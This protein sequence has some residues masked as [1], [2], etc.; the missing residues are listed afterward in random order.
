MQS[1]PQL[2]PHDFFAVALACVAIRDSALM[3]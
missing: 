1:H 3:K 2:S